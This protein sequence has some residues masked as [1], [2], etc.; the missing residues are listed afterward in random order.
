MLV[1]V[2]KCHRKS[3][4]SRDPSKRVVCPAACPHI[5]IHIIIDIDIHI[6]IH[7][8]WRAYFGASC[9][10]GAVHSGRVE[11]YTGEGFTRERWG[12]CCASLGF[13]LRG[14]AVY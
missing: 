12:L 6:N 5:H 14:A 1:V 2:V 13:A 8:Y 4:L 7:N 10:G 3:E 9:Y 11:L